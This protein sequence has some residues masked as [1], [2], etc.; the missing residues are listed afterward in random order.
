[1]LS[2]FETELESLLANPMHCPLKRFIAVSKDILVLVDGSKNI[3][4]NTFP[5]NSS[6]IALD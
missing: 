2:P 1:M 6:E 3:K 4:P 5:F